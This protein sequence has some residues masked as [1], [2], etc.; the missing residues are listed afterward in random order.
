MAKVVRKRLGDILVDAGVLT[1]QEI[2]EAVQK[3]YPD[4][5]TGDVITRLGYAT[6]AKV[7]D[8]LQEVSGIPRTNLKQYNIAKSITSLVPKD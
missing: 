3:R 6:E 4:E 7:Q 8:A 1:R 2:E 5:K